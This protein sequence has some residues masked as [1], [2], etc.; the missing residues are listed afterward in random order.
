[1]SLCFLCFEKKKSISTKQFPFQH[2]SHS[3]GSPLDLTVQWYNSSHAGLQ[4]THWG[5]QHKGMTSLTVVS[6]IIWLG[7]SPIYS[8]R[9][10]WPNM[11]NFDLCHVTRLHKGPIITNRWKCSL[12]KIH[13]YLFAGQEWETFLDLL[14]WN[15]INPLGNTGLPGNFQ[16]SWH[17]PWWLLVDLTKYTCIYR[18]C[19]LN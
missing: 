2:S 10:T 11:V 6:S 13:S 16:A 19:A 12:K 5:I 8:T 14:P 9:N 15:Q 18:I 7:S 3:S 17:L 1:M 4:V